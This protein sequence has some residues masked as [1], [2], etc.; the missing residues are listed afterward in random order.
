VDPLT[1]GLGQCDEVHPICSNC[2]RRELACV[3]DPRPAV[4]PPL[5]RIEVQSLLSSSSPTPPRQPPAQPEDASRAFLALHASALPQTPSAAPGLD[6]ARLEL[7]H[8]YSTCT[9]ASFTSHAEWQLAWRDTVP[10]LGF[11][12]PFVMHA[13]LAV[14][15]LHLS[16]LNHARSEHYLLLAAR[17]Y[18]DASVALRCALPHRRTLEGNALFVA[19]SFIAIYVFAS[20]PVN[21]PV[22]AEPRALAW[23]PVLRGIQ[24]VV[25]GEWSQVAGELAPSLLGNRPA[26]ATA[27]PVPAPPGVS[28]LPPLPPLDGL[29]A[30]VVDPEECRIYAEAAA[31]LRCTW[32]MFRAASGELWLPM[33]FLWP[34]TLCDGFVA[35]LMRKRPRALVLLAHYNAMF[36]MLQGF[37]WIGKTARDELRVIEAAVGEA[38]SNEWLGWV[39]Q[40]VG[41]E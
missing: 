41:R 14:S 9:Y 1:R 6:L 16:V 33:A 10:K 15:A 36:A 29:C 11:Q 7:L 35:L 13:T 5:P 25:R 17:Y 4:P 2:S 34:V 18:H 24:A 32:D 39:R 23:F 19:S 12:Y 27:A 3:Y 26:A 30:N 31:K 8:Q 22:G 37:W 38:W 20:P 40:V 28:A 21:A